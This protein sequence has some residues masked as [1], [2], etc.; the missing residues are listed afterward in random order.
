MWS[1]RNTLK[2]QDFIIE[3]IENNQV[4][5]SILKRREDYFELLQIL[6]N[7][8]VLRVNEPELSLEE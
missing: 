5:L 8:K 4:I 2:Q 3:T 1:T 7:Y 6:S